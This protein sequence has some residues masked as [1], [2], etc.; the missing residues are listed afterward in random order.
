MYV[1]LKGKCKVN[2]LDEHFTHWMYIYM[3][4]ERQQLASETDMICF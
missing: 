3:Y 1:Y 2:R 4:Q